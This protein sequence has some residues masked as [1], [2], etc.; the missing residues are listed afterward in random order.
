MSGNGNSALLVAQAGHLGVILVFSPLTPTL[1]QS[2]YHISS[3]SKQM[4]KESN[5]SNIFQ[6]AVHISL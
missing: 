5:P 1:N 3:T 4:T 2:E 6:I